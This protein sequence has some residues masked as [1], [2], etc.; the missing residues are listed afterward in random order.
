MCGIFSVPATMFF[1]PFFMG[2][3]TE[4]AFEISAYILPVSSFFIWAI[5]KT[6]KSARLKIIVNDIGILVEDFKD[7]PISWNTLV[8]SKVVSQRVRN[9][10]TAH[11]LVIS[12]KNDS[13]LASKSLNQ[14]N[15]YLLG[16]GVPICNLTTYKVEPLELVELINTK[17]SGKHSNKAIKRK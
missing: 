13:L 10:P 6:W 12:T 9:G 7:E 11:W 17:I 3:L 2:G 1:L 15:K 5:Y 16:G 8:C 4:R 14:I